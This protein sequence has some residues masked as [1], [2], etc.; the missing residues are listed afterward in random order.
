VIRYVEIDPLRGRHSVDPN[1]DEGR[2]YRD[3][4]ADEKTHIS[5][6]TIGSV[7]WRW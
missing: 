7:A 3:T 2:D 6:S 5:L 4:K 1:S